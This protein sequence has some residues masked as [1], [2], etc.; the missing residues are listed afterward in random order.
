MPRLSKKM[1]FW[2][3]LFLA[4]AAA[5][6]YMWLPRDRVVEID[7]RKFL[8]PAGFSGSSYGKSSG[9]AVSALWPEM[10][11]WTKAATA[12]VGP[13]ECASLYVYAGQA[14]LARHPD[15]ERTANDWAQQHQKTLVHVGEKFGLDQWNEVDE[16][17]GAWQ[18]L[19]FS[20]TP[21]GVDFIAE[22]VAPEEGKP[23]KCNSLH[24]YKGA[25]RIGIN[26]AAACL[27]NWREIKAAA[28]SLVE[29][30]EKAAE[31]K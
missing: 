22:C 15:L 19:Y 16:K 23:P 2:L 4:L 26:Q 6:A 10:T 14:D 17:G 21:Q 9:V 1:K 8:V 5:G 13:S 27:E 3:G 18:E 7:G 25:I 31:G 24:V 30:F 12:G 20:R 11:P 29:G 28:T